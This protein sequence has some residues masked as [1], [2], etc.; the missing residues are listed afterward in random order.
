[1][2]LKKSYSLAMTY[3]LL[4]TADDKVQILICL[5]AL[6]FVVVEVVEVI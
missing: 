5:T 3:M 6:K 1:M 2:L 4:R